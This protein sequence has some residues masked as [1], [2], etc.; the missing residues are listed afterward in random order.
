MSI[1]TIALTLRPDAAQVAMLERLQQRWVAACAFIS[2]LAWRERLWNANSLQRRVY[3]EVRQ[4]FDLLAQHT[5]LA[6]RAVAASYRTDRTCCHVFRRTSAVIFDAR[7]YHLRATVV[8][9][10][11]PEGRLR[12]PVTLGGTQ[13]AQLAAATSLA[14]ADLVRDEQGRWRLLVAAQYADPPSSTPTDVLGVDLGVVNI[15]ADSDGTLYSGAQLRGLR[16]RHRRLRTRLQAKGTKSARRLLRKRSRRERRFARDTNHVI[17]KRIVAVAQRTGR[18]IALEELT[19]IRGR[20]TARKPQRATLHSWAFG[21]LR[22]FIEYKA[23]MGGVLVVAV[24][25]RNSSRTCP[26]CGYVAKANRPSQ[27]TFYCQSCSFSGVADLVAAT[28]LRDRGRA[29]V[30]QP[31]VSAAGS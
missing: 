24:D 21:Q 6:V 5:C 4:R 12:I 16:I 25:P 26:A 8:Y 29:A 1:R 18:G 15:A 20:V 28:V 23:Q 13:R 30:M 14:Q 17:S 7:L 19:H 10:A 22:Q 3:G 11:T 27:A 9:L 31:H 2:A